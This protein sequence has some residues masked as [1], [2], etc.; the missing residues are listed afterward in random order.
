MTSSANL[1]TLSRSFF[2][3]Q[4]CDRQFATDEALQSHLQHS[5]R[6]FWCN[7]CNRLFNSEEALESHLSTAKAHKWCH[8]CSPCNLVFNSQEALESHLST[9]EAHTR[10]Y[11]CSPCNLLFNSEVALESH[12]F[13]SEAH[14]W[15]YT[16]NRGFI[17]AGA[18]QSHMRNAVVH[19]YAL[20]NSMTPQQPSTAPQ[21][22]NCCD[23]CNIS[24]KEPFQLREVSV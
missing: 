17:S 21:P 12:L 2:E 16:C 9:S 5:S 13:T 10:C 1:L 6:H 7:P 23:K 18:L 15:C 4:P 14:T 20:A 8:T 11:T 22:T 24:F 19:R 3:C